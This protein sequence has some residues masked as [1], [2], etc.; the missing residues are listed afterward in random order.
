MQEES[1]ACNFVRYALKKWCANKFCVRPEKHHN[2]LSIKITFLFFTVLT[3]FNNLF[4]ILFILKIYVFF[5]KGQSKLSNLQSDKKQFT[6]FKK[7]FL[8][9]IFWKHVNGFFKQNNIK[10]MYL[11][12]KQLCTLHA[13]FHISPPTTK[14]SY[15]LNKMTTTCCAFVTS[16]RGPNCT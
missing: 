5:L 14:L 9:C 8:C 13:S 4:N 7:K 10:K 15:I 6:A 2:V 12:K 3:I 1:S 16:F 11:Y